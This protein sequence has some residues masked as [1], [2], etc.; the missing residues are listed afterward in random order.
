M[1]AVF[2]S[3]PITRRALL[4]T[5][6]TSAAAAMLSGC[7]TSTRA[8]RDVPAATPPENFGSAISM[9]AAVEDGGHQIPAVPAEKID[10][11]Y[12]R[13]VVIDPTGEAP[14]TVVVDTEIISSTSWSVSAAPCATVSALAGRA[15]NGRAMASSNGSSIGH[16]GSRRTR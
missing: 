15:S 9:Y 13:Q 14:G 11:R 8:Q 4:A 1:S 5:A 10:P 7:T 3:F 16:A 2:P 12:H 6:S